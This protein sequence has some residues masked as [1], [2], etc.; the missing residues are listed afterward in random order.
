M[1]YADIVI[2][3][4]GASGM[5]AACHI[6]AA[7][8]T[9]KKI[10]ILEHKNAPAKKLLATGNGRCNFTNEITD[11]ESFRGNA[12]EFAYDLIKQYDKKWLLGWLKDIGVVH[13][14]ING[15][16]YP[17]SL[18]ASAVA[19]SLISKTDGYGIRIR[20]NEHVKDIKKENGQFIITSDKESYT[21][22]YVVLA[23]GGKAY[24]AL[25]SDG[26]GYM[27][28]GKL[29]HTV[30]SL[31]PS[32]T[33]LIMEGMAF[34]SCSGVRAKA[35][36]KLYDS[37]TLIKENYGEVQF[38]DYGISGIPVFQISRYAAQ[39]AENKK[40]VRISL[41]L[42][43]E[44]S[45]DELYAVLKEISEKNPKKPICD[46]LNAVIPYKLAKTI[47]GMRKK[48]PGDLFLICGMLKDLTLNVRSVMPFDKA[49]VTAGGVYTGEVNK[50]TMESLIC[51]GLYLT[52]ELL[53][54]DG[55]CGGYNLH[56]AFASGACAGMDIGGKL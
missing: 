27:L 9:K 16:Y 22:K 55:N 28:A 30:S 17:R 18:Q 43:A 1:T 52:G 13:T 49:Q 40:R 4:A 8:K 14:Q 56:F 3:G 46:I 21:A 23:A 6:G 51:G 33:G 48:D 19:N 47:C 29:G 15:Y 42:A 38:T 39:L 11:E 37:D 25:G 7:A 5:A 45:F 32:L 26:S 34:K 50:H 10:Y 35:G 24:P 12:P 54:I 36:I 41:D 44:Y 20:L 53:D 31:Y 2:V